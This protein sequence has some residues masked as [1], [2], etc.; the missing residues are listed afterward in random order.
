MTCDWELCV[1]STALSSSVW[2]KCEPCDRDRDVLQQ[3]HRFQLISGFQILENSEFKISNFE[4]TF[5]KFVL[6]LF[7]NRSGM[8]HILKYLEHERVLFMNPLGLLALGGRLE[9]P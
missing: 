2:K 8:L 3:L 7:G 1:L 4:T 5:F 6:V 9:T